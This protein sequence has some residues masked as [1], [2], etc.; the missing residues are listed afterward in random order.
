MAYACSAAAEKHGKCAQVA[1][2]TANLTKEVACAAQEHQSLW[3]GVSIAAKELSQHIGELHGLN[4]RRRRQF[5]RTTKDVAKSLSLLVKALE[6]YAVWLS[7]KKYFPANYPLR[8]SI[9]GRRFDQLRDSLIG[10]GEQTEVVPVP[11]AQLTGA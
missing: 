7:L 9:G 5:S 1:G 2:E 11:L 3:A 10:N 6:E 4:P 8:S